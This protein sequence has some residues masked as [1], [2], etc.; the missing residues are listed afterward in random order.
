[1]KGIIMANKKIEK[2]LK[3]ATTAN[4]KHAAAVAENENRLREL[5]AQKAALEEAFSNIAAED[6]DSFKAQ[7]SEFKTKM[8]NIDSEIGFCEFR[9]R[10]LMKT[11]TTDRPAEIDIIQKEYEKHRAEIRARLEPKIEEMISIIDAGDEEVDT[12]KRARDAV[13]E[14]YNISRSIVFPHMYPHTGLVGQVGPLY[15]TLDDTLK[16]LKKLD[17]DEGKK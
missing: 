3:E 6:L 12:M 15:E 2:I 9:K 17:S 8:N 1:M 4:S 16:R 13:I 5:T 7:T 10:A 14:R 11:E